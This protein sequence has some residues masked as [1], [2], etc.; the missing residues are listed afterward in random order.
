MKSRKQEQCEKRV[1]APV[2]GTRG[3]SSGR[4]WNKKVHHCQHGVACNSLPQAT[5]V[6]MNTR[7]DLLGVKKFRFS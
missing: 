7:T 4:E 1:A 5:V 6:M 3:D 2:C